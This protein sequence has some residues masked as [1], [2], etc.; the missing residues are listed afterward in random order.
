MKR[1]T[2]FRIVQWLGFGV[3]VSVFITRQRPYA[4]DREFFWDV[5]VFTCA[6][7]G[8]TIFVL[9]LI[10]IHGIIETI[11]ERKKRSAL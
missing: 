2:K 1:L 5:F 11:R 3:I 7:A 10:A 8:W 6:T 9:A 4:T